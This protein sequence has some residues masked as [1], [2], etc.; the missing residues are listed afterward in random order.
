[1]TDAELT[2][3]YNEANGIVSGKRPML[4]TARIFTAMRAVA[5][6]EQAK[7]ADLKE[8]VEAFYKADKDCDR[9]TAMLLSCGSDPEPERLMDVREEAERKMFELIGVTE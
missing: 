6:K 5:A 3:I 1:M 9:C 2:V 7:A 4:T 8:A